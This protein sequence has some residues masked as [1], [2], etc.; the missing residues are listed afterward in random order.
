MP[1]T[2]L[3]P[4]GH[5]LTCPD[6][7]AGKAG[8]CPHCGA[9]FRIPEPTPPTTPAIGAGMPVISMTR[10]KAKPKPAATAA[11]AAAPA[12]KAVEAVATVQ[13]AAEPAAAPAPVVAAVA[14]P[15]P[16]ASPI[17]SIDS[18]GDAEPGDDEV[19]FM[20]PE[21]HHLCGPAT[22]VD[23]PGECP[24]CHVKFIVPGPEE[25][26]EEQEPEIHLDQLLAS[27]AAPEG[28][29]FGDNSEEGAPRGLGAL[30]LQLWKYRA[31]GCAI[32]LHLG[33]GRVLVPSGFAVESAGLSHGL[34]T[35][36]EPNGAV[37][38]TVVAWDTIERLN[39]RGLFHLPRGITFDLP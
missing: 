33:E 10:P 4:N 14:E 32:E 35:V 20:C 9:K 18:A 37:T 15:E 16:E 12:P 28:F 36:G 5:K 21:G 22:L 26:V 24:I 39:V 7:L 29:S 25:L 11:P 3:C 13:P 8:K 2:I 1:I 34:F 6:S 31:Q 23:Q 27:A 38:M 30:F 19:V 17:R